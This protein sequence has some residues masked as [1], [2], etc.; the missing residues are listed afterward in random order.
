MNEISYKLKTNLKKKIRKKKNI[1]HT[2]IWT[3]NS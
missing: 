2:D 1:Q 3:K